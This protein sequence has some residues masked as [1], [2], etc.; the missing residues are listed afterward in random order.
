MS[1]CGQH[2]KDTFENVIP[3]SC[4]QEEQKSDLWI[5]TNS[6]SANLISRSSRISKVA[7]TLFCLTMSSSTSCISVALSSQV[8]DLVKS[9]QSAIDLP[10]G[11]RSVSKH[12]HILQ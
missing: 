8:E 4:K 10:W 12:G 3:F 11:L 2:N 1:L 7:Q 5:M 6:F 9:L